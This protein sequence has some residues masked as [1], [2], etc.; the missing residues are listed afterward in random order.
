[1]PAPPRLAQWLLDWLAPGNEALRGDLDEELANGRNRRWYWR[2]VLSAITHEGTLRVRARAIYRVESYV[3]GFI[4]LILV[5]FYAVF[6]INVTDWLLRFEGVHLLLRLPDV[7]G[8]VDGIAPLVALVIGGSIG[9]I[10]LA[11]HLH[12]RLATVVLFGSTT[13]LCAATAL[14]AV[15]VAAGSIVFL[16]NLVPQVTTTSLFVLGLIG[17]LA[18]LGVRRPIVSI[19]A[20]GRA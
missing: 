5:G 17:G 7:L 11:G 13:M 9:R 16:P 14:K 1:M 3:T 20:I 8:P 15:S 10:V 4:T 18:T 2:Q 19:G 6:V 12:H